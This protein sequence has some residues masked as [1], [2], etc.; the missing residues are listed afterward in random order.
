[1][2]PPPS[3]PPQPANNND[4]RS[5]DHPK[6]CPWHPGQHSKHRCILNPDGPNFRIPHPRAEATTAAGIPAPSTNNPLP[7]TQSNLNNEAA[8][9]SGIPTGTGIPTSSLKAHHNPYSKQN[10]STRYGRG[11]AK[12]GGGRGPG[13]QDDSVPII[14]PHNLLMSTKAGKA[15]AILLGRSNPAFP[16]S[17]KSLAYSNL[18]VYEQDY[19]KVSI[20]ASRI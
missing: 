19:I 7:T 5:G 14:L 3:T 15:T 8:S 13:D 9:T 16:I 20:V 12:G 11:Y 17:F 1:M 18:T 10:Q 6:D 4:A 2:T